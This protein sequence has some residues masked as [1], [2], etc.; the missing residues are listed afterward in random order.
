VADDLGWL[1][2]MLSFLEALCDK[3]AV[4]DRRVPEEMAARRAKDS[5]IAWPARSPSSSNSS[6]AL[7]DAG[8]AAEASLDLARVRSMKR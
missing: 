5:Q 1:E 3:P 4:S 7:A 2:N 6:I 8:S